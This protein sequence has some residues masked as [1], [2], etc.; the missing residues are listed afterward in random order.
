MPSTPADARDEQMMRSV[1]LLAIS[2]TAV[3]VVASGCAKV[4]AQD[5]TASSA[6]VA[7]TYQE[8][9][10]ALLGTPEERSAAEAKAVAA[11]QQSIADCMSGKGLSYTAAPSE[12]PVAGPIVLN[13]LTSLAPLGEHGFGI[14]AFK[15]N[16]A[17]AADATA[18]N[19]YGVLKTEAERAAYGAALGPCITAAPDVAAFAPDGQGELVA[20]LEKVFAEQ[21]K[22]PAVVAKLDEYGDCM[23][24][25]GYPVR[26]YLDLYQL[27]ESRFP[28]PGLGWKK[29][30]NGSAWAEAAAFER[31]AADTDAACRT[32]LRNHVM[33]AARPALDRFAEKHADALTAMKQQWA[34]Y[35][36]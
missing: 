32:D 5:A 30:A 24:K 2:A 14:T 25:A 3:A 33:A 7:A 27:I 35:R 10:D 15:Q 11:F 36:G 17:R 12:N 16:V 31:A 29:L 4:S 23:A 18:D 13:D 19:A 20:E 28:D 21:E 34:D 9:L 6:G 26:T 8:L 22:N 1:G